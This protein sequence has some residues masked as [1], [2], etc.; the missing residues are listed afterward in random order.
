[1]REAR[2]Q[3]GILALSDHIGEVLSSSA[4][5]VAELV[6]LRSAKK[7]IND[8]AFDMINNLLEKKLLST[9]ELWK[10]SISVANTLRPVAGNIFTSWVC[11]ILN[12]GFKEN[13]LSLIA[14][15]KGKIRKELSNKL[16]YT[17]SRKRIVDMKPDID[18]VVYTKTD[19]NPI[20]IVSCK[21]T[22]AERVLQTLRWKQ[23]VEQLPGEVGMLK[24]FLVTAW[25]TFK[26]QTNRARVSV[27]D[28]VYAAN[29]NVIE[30]DNIKR[31]S[32]IF[33]DLKKL[34]HEQLDSK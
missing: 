7:N 28:G 13:N 16:K 34:V 18:I 32:C 23:Q 3:Y 8:E 21:T 9:R 12:E 2:K 22:L 25:E 30:G 6:V 27:L 14:I 33:D 20:A 31:L 11:L 5:E 10:F 4:N 29:E 1:M 19:D 17:D 26:E 24:I 15:T